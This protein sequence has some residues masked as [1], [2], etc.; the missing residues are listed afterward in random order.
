MNVLPFSHLGL[1]CPKCLDSP[2]WCGSCS[3]TQNCCSH[4]ARSR[5]ELGKKDGEKDKIVGRKRAKMLILRV[6]VDRFFV[7][8]SQLLTASGEALFCRVNECIR[9]VSGVCASENL[10]NHN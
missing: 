8:V 4:P 5:L 6:K 2:M 7:T 1:Q 10:A 9:R 3:C